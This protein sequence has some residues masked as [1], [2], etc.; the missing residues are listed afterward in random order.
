MQTQNVWNLPQFHQ[1]FVFSSLYAENVNDIVVTWS[2]MS[3]V[4]ENG[5]VVEYGINGFVLRATGTTE[6]FVDGG[7]EQRSQYIHRVSWGNL[8]KESFNL[9]FI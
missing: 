9:Y 5:A 1:S 6:K 4:G 7:S 2:T 8:L 3:D